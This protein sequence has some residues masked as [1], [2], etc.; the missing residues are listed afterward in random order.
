MHDGHAAASVIAAADL[1]RCARQAVA[2]GHHAALRIH[3][4]APTGSPLDGL[5][6]YEARGIPHLVCR[7]GS[8]IAAAVGRTA[9]LTVHAGLDPE[10]FAA[11]TEAAVILSGRLCHSRH[12]PSLPG[13]LVTLALRLDDVHIEL[14]GGPGPS[15][16]SAIRLGVYLGVQADP[17]I[18]YAV[19]LAQ[20][21]NGCHRAE[22]RAGAARLAGLDEGE[23]AEASV[24]EV[25]RVSA[26]LQWIDSS[27][28]HSRTLRFSTPAVDP[29]SLDHLLR[30][31]LAG[32]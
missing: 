6:L 3:G 24:A 27:G 30:E 17:F 18:D 22:L 20:H 28:A 4:L 26:R 13:D 25:T 29:V 12:Q 31:Q 32:C 16:S 1:A 5:Q 19:S 11:R 10:R 23:I 9:Q 8:A 7:A 21:L 2:T 15:V 14:S